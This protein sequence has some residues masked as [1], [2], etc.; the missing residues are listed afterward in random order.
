MELM[1][2][3]ES[4]NSVQTNAGT[5]ET[6]GLAKH[7]LLTTIGGSTWKTTWGEGRDAVSVDIVR[8]Y[9]T[10]GPTI[11]AAGSVCLLAEGL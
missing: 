11:T 5:K 1:S 8:I 2:T 4:K 3:S 10:A 9:Q 6:W 7:D